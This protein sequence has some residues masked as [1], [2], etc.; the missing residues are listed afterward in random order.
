MKESNNDLN[1][2]SQRGWTESQQTGAGGKCLESY[3]T[4]LR[5]QSGI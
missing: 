1:L 3:Q 5:R 4:T 2:G